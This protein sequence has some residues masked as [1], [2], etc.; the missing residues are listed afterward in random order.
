MQLSV[1]LVPPLMVGMIAGIMFRRV[2]RDGVAPGADGIKVLMAAIIFWALADFARRLIVDP[3]VTNVV[4]VLRLTCAM[5]TVSGW[6]MFAVGYAR[7][8]F[9]LPKPVRLYSWI[10]PVILT[11]FAVTNPYHG[12]VYQDIEVVLD[13]AYGIIQRTDQRGPV[14]SLFVLAG[15]IVTLAGSSIMIFAVSSSRSSN[16]ALTMLVFATFIAPIAGMVQR[17]ASGWVHH[18][19][20]TLM[21]EMII[22]VTLYLSLYRTRLLSTLP[23]VR[24]RIV[25]EVQDPIVVVNARREIIDVNPAGAAMLG[26]DRDTLK[27]VSIDSLL[28]AWPAQDLAQTGRAQSEVSLDDRSYEVS[29]SRIE[30]ESDNSDVALLFRDMT[31]RLKYERKLIEMQEVSRRLAETDSL[32]GLVNRRVFEQA[33]GDANQACREPKDGFT[34]LLIDLDRFKVVNDTAGHAAGDALLR[35]VAA[36]LGKAVRPDDL[37]ARL[38]GDEFAILL[39][40]CNKSNAAQVAEKMRKA[41]DEL[42][43]SWEGSVF[44]IGASIGVVCISHA[45]PDISEC[46]VSADMAC[47]AAK[48]GGRNQA[49]VVEERTGEMEERRSVGLWV[50]RLKQAIEEDAFVLFCQDIMPV[51]DPTLP[52]RREILLRLRDRRRDTLI[53]PG[54][55]LP[56]AERYDLCADIDEWVVRATIEALR[57][58]P[59]LVAQ[60]VT[61]WLNL[62]G[63][64][65]SDLRFLASLENMVTGAGLP[66]GCLNFEI[67]ETAAIRRPDAAVDAITRLQSLG[68]RFALDDFGAGVSSF[69]YLKSLP[70]DD[71]KI[72]GSFIRDLKDDKVN[73]IFVKSMIDIAREMGM[74]SVAEFVEDEALLDIVTELGAD[75]AQG[76]GLDRPRPL[77]PEAPAQASQSRVASGA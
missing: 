21:S 31:S 35:N 7:R 19:D 55:F 33:L 12:L 68:C 37:V 32:T 61:Y 52:A 59:K 16:I 8:Q 11:L 6:L 50:Q 53:P 1:W 64:S 36:V 40:G 62:S 25:H 24:D 2:L 10:V 15:M 73:R 77:L 48:E 26:E 65:V 23:L 74:K 39:R 43:F 28:S 47:L 27:Y 60:N 3:A 29:F 76:F 46:L 30:S 22:M 14:L 63:R 38:G 69:S 45:A 70:V 42:V 34:V 13:P 57:A 54:A 18:V 56:A 58:H 67:T 51:Q 72:D 4:A 75:Y 44:R 17:N 20:L 71:I 66:R 5:T 49:V 41:V 9:V